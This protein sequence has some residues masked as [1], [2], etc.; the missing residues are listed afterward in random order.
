MAL[1]SHLA[2]ANGVTTSRHVVGNAVEVLEAFKGHRLP[3]AL[4]G[5]NHSVEKDVYITEAGPLRFEQTSAIH[6]RGGVGPF[7]VPS[8]FTL[9]RVKNGAIDAGTFVRMDPPG[10][11]TN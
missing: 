5:H 7:Y 11:L 4:G 2:H 8:G 1:V 3:L 9:Y 6:E 10:S